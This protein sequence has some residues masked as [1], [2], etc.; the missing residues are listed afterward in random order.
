M[1]SF[2][3]ILLLALAI[4][5]SAVYCMEP[6]SHLSNLPEELKVLIISFLTHSRTLN[7]AVKSI[8][9]LALTNKE[10][11]RIIT[12]DDQLTGQIIE[13]LAK[14]FKTDIN[15]DVISHLNSEITPE[16][17][18]TQSKMASFHDGYYK[19]FVASRLGTP[20]AIRWAKNYIAKEKIKPVTYYDEPTL[21][22]FIKKLK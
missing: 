17:L 1:N 4:Q 5:S 7:E 16:K 15:K 13:D 2:S 20:A 6:A 10:F 11:N 19:L 12:T 14:Q 3:K 9:N 18:E 22:A 8:Q 21:Q